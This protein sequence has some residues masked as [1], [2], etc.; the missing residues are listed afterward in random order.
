MAAGEEGVGEEG[1]ISEGFYDDIA[2]FEL[3]LI[4]CRTELAII[5]IKLFRP[6]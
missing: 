1:V 2:G 4:S 6:M 3:A 5:R